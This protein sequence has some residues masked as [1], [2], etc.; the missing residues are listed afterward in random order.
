MFG[1]RMGLAPSH[2]WVTALRGL[3]AICFGVLALVRPGLALTALIY[4]FAAYALIDGIFS[5]WMG[6]QLRQLRDIWPYWWATL[7]EGIAGI[8]IGL[9]AFFWPGITAQAII[10][11]I[12]AWAIVT[13]IFELMTVFT[14]RALAVQE[15]TMAIAGILSIILGILLFMQPGAGMLTMAWLVGI[16][17]IAWGIVLIARAFQFRTAVL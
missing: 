10:M 13:G 9:I 11:L 17:A 8:I 5:I 1:S 7:L 3:V 14:G 6:F 12:A 4:L 2:W 16:Y 15:W